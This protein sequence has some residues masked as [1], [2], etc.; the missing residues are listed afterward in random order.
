MVTCSVE[1]LTTHNEA[2]LSKP[3]AVADAPHEFMEKLIGNIVGF[4]SKPATTEFSVIEGLKES[5]LQESSDMA[6]LVEAATKNA[7]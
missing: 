7:R 4:E 2:S 3:W 1:S 5:G 6:M